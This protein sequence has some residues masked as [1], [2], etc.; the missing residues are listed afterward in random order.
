M[1]YNLVLCGGVGSR[2]WPLSRKSNPKQY[3]KLFDGQSLFQKTILRNIEYVDGFMTVGNQLN[4]KLSNNQLSEIG[5]KPIVEIV[6]TI[7]KNTAPAIAFGALSVIADD[8]LFVT[9]SDHIIVNDENYKVSIARAIELAKLGN[10]VTFGIKPSYPEVGYGYI[11]FADEDVLN[12][13]EKP[14]IEKAKV[15]L[16]SGQ[17]LWNSG[18]FCFKASVF[19]EELKKYEPVMYE[20]IITAYKGINSNTLPEIQSSKILG[21]SIDYAVLEKSNKVKVVKSDIDWSDMGSYQSLWDYYKKYNPE[22]FIN[23]NLILSDKKV[24]CL[25]GLK[26][27]IFVDTEDSALIISKD[28]TNDIKEI[29]KNVETNMPNLI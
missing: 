1:V 22:K 18:M 25:H 6:E 23:E 7:A 29:Y 20:Q 21:N 26:N 15:F 2:L 8:I 9:P 14:D 3:L 10:I 19:L 24:V 12:F 13:E 28:Q 5:V 11:R 16:E 27:M 4:N 17:F